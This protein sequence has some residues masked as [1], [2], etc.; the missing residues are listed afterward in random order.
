MKEGKYL[1]DCEK[2]PLYKMGKKL[3]FS[4]D[5]TIGE[6]LT[7]SDV[8]IVSPNDGIPPYEL[9]NLLNHVVNYN[10]SQDETIK[11]EYIE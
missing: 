2:K 10:Y 7:A 3:V 8:K 1:L 11:Q 5:M 6:I 4:R 9:D